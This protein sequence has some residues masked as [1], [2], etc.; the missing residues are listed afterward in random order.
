MVKKKQSKELTVTPK[1]LIIMPKDVVPSVVPAFSSKQIAR[2]MTETPQQHIGEIEKG[3]RKFKYV[4]GGYMRRELDVLFGFD[5]DFEIISKE[6]DGDDIVVQGKLTGRITDPKTGAVRQITKTQFGG[7]KVK[8]T[9]KDGKPMDIGNDYKAAAT[10][11]LKKC[12]A[13][14]GICRDIYYSNEFVEAKIYQEDAKK[15]SREIAGGEV[16]ANNAKPISDARKKAIVNWLDQ[17]QINDKM[18]I[19][20]DVTGKLTIK[21]ETMNEYQWRDLNDRYKR[22]K[23]ENK[24]A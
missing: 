16:I 24:N 6:R 10:D 18:R 15:E 3:G 17:L 21:A 20:K 22:A 4:S 7:A 9:K 8:Y 19:V 13:E 12:A 14:F 23:K 11:A 2:M 1:D 5:W